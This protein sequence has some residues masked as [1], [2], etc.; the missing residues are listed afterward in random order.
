[1]G[2]PLSTVIRRTWVHRLL[3]VTNG[4]KVEFSKE[5][6]GE[7]QNGKAHI[8]QTQENLAEGLLTKSFSRKS[9]DEETSTVQRRGAPGGRKE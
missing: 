5:V 9:P 6:M 8:S 3:K 2:T 4:L 7:S 1:M